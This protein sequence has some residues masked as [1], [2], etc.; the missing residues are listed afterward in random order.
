VSTI[1]LLYGS[2]NQSITC[3]LASLANN[4]QR[5]STAVDNT[6]NL[7]E[8]ALLAIKVKSGASGVSATG[9]VNIYLVGTADGGSTYAEA[10]TGTDA[11]ITLTSPPN[12]R[13]IGT[14]NVVA[15]AT[16]YEAVFDVAKAMDGTLPDHWVIVVENKTGAA[17]DA[18][19]GNHL[20]IYQGV[21]RQAV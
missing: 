17:L 14:I 5:A 19:E 9:V 20:K 12:V 6:S 13:L 4:G 15:N 11:G 3:T 18:T 1:K 2:N 16:S 8:T 10:A 21:Q 7:F